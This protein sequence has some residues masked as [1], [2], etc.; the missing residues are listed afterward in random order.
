MVVLPDIVIPSGSFGFEFEMV[1]QTRSQVGIIAVGIFLFFGAAMA[2]LAGTT[3]IW[4]GTVL[5]R[6]WSIN[7]AAYARLAPFGKRIGI[8]LPLLSAMLAIAGIGW[9]GRRLWAWRLAVFIIATQVLGDLV[10]VFMGDVVRGGVGF[11]IAGT[12]LF[13][14][15]S[16]EMRSAFERG[17]ASP[18]VDEFE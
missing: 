1:V 18:S 6:T 9:F 13:Y 16:P 4:R 14:L 2:L 12:L 11:V 3:L 17:N 15:L 7:A 5:D 10:N 8:P